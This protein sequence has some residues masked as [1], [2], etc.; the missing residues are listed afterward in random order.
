[1]S[2]SVTVAVVS[3]NTR[4]LL[5]RCLHSLQPDVDAG[6]AEVYVVDNESADG[7]PTLV[8]DEFPWATLIEP[9][10][11]LGYGRA[12]NTVA[13]RTSTPWLAASNADVELEPGALARLLEAGSPA[14][15]GAV[16]P[17]LILP[18]GSTQH[19]AYGFPTLPYLLAFNIGLYRV[20][21][22]LGDRLLIEGHWDPSR[23]RDVPWAVGAFLL[24]RRDAFDAAG[25]FDPGQWMYAEDVDLGWRLGRAGWRTRYEPS[26]RVRHAHGAAAR[27]AFGERPYWRWMD[28]TYNWIER[29]RGRVRRIAAALISVAGAVARRDREWTRVHLRGLQR[30]A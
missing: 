26:A 4:E 19:S 8:R 2:T 6:L 1:M 30:R 18:D 9:G 5:G 22:G 25:G 16:A 29:R 13:E 10:E 11:N 21:P 27:Q 7:S 24:L 17:Q 12:V 3:W 28:A 20:I 15:V 23:P 14:D